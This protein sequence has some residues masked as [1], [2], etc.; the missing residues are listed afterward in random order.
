[1][2]AIIIWGNSLV[3]KQKILFEQYVKSKTLLRENLDDVIRRE[4]FLRDARAYYQARNPGAANEMKNE[5]IVTNELNALTRTQL[6]QHIKAEKITN[7]NNNY[8]LPKPIEED[9]SIDKIERKILTI[10]ANKEDGASIV[11]IITATRAPRIKIIPILEQ[12]QK[13]ELIVVDNNEEGTVI[14]KLY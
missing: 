1:M 13:D 8:H 14:Y 2:T 7:I 4:A 6:H 10:C 9:N 11:D 5:M 12:L 3:A